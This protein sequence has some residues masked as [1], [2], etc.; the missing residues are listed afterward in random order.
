MKRWILKIVLINGSSYFQWWKLPIM[1]CEKENLLRGPWPSGESW[2]RIMKIIPLPN[3]PATTQIKSR[4]EKKITKSKDESN[5]V[6]CSFNNYFHENYISH[7]TKRIW[8]YLKRKYAGDERIWGMQ[9]LNLTSRFEL[10]RMKDSETVKEY[11]DRLLGI[12]SK[13]RLLCIEL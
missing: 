13:V 1:G 4:K 10:Q 11:S 2:K 9:I 6:C 3:D 7:I 12:F 5:F 8:D